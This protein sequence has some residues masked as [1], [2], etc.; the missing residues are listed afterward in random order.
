MNLYDKA[1]EIMKDG[2]LSLRKWNSDRQSFR[3]KIKQNEERK[4]WS[5]MEAPPKESVITQYL[6]KE[7]SSV[8]KDGKLEKEQLVK[9]LGIYY[10]LIQDDFCYDLSEL[11]EYAEALPATKRSVLK[12]SAKIFDAIGL[13][14]S[15]TMNVRVLF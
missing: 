15:F 14:T 13:L 6:K 11:I 2:G 3:E 10:D 8:A 12:L 9:I 5:D 4:S 7:E 1:Q